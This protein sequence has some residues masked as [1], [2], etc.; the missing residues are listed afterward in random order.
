MIDLLD[1]TIYP[2]HYSGD[3]RTDDQYLEIIE[4]Y[5]LPR[6]HIILAS[7]VYW[8]TMSGTMKHFVDRF[9][10]LLTTHKGLGRQLRGKTLGVLSC[11]K[12][13]EIIPTFFT[14]FRLTAEYL[15]MQYGPEYH[16]WCPPATPSAMLVRRLRGHD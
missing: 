1:Y 3:Y 16:G 13:A 15:G 12:D 11:A 14:P 4:N 10:D 7:P 9:S 5:V 6:Q 2:Y 8:Y